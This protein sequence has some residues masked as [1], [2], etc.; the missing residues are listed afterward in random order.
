MK[1]IIVFR[2][3]HSGNFLKNLIQGKG[4][5]NFR[6]YDRKA[7]LESWV[8]LTHDVDYEFHR[9]RYDL[10]LRILPQKKI[11]NSIYNIFMKKTLMDEYPDFDLSSWRQDLIYWYDRC[12]YHLE[13]YYRLIKQDIAEN[14]YPQVVEFDRIMDHDYLES[15]LSNKLGIN[16]D[17]NRVR[18]LEEYRSLQLPL[19]L[20][21]DT[22]SDMGEISA[23]FTDAM[24]R[25]N[26][27]FWAYCVFKFEINNGFREDQRRWSVNDVARVQTKQDLLDISTR[28][29]L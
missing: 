12:Y 3:G 26:P 13:H 28:Y 22:Q 9:D 14:Q 5:P 18:M 17:E 11:Y 8:H 6:I 20:T 4:V 1:V 29:Q 7:M 23:V 16:L 2:E 21:D 19:E 15:L 24:L 27:W 25:D 10:V